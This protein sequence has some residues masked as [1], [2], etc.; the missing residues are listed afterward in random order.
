MKK[1]KNNPLKKNNNLVKRSVFIIL[2]SILLSAVLAL[3]IY[4][5]YNRFKDDLIRNEQDRLL[6]IADT[7]ARSIE[8]YISNQQSIL[9]ILERDLDVRAF[10]EESSDQK[11]L[12]V[13]DKMQ[14]FLS[15]QKNGFEGIQLYRTSSAL[16]GTYLEPYKKNANDNIEDVKE[17]F[18]TNLQTASEVYF[19]EGK[20]PYF[21][22]N[23]PIWNEEKVIGNIRARISIN[24]IYQ[25]FIQPIKFEKKGYAS[26]KTSSSVFIMH[27]KADQLGQ[28]VLKIR[29]EKYPNYDWS[30]LEEMFDKQM[31]GERG[32]GVYK[33]VWVTDEKPKLTLKF[34]GYS[35]AYFG[36][37]F[38]IVTVSSDYYEATKYIRT[39]LY[40]TIIVMSIIALSCSLSALYIVFMMMKQKKLNEVGVLLARVQDLNS[41]LENDIEQ[42]IILENNLRE[43]R[44]KF[45][46]LFNTGTQLTF[47][48]NASSIKEGGLEILEVN[49][50]ACERLG[51]TRDELFQMKLSDILENMTDQLITGIEKNR[52][53]KMMTE[54]R[55]IC[56]ETNFTTSR[57]DVFPVELY[58]HEFIMEES[59]FLMFV[60]RDI[61]E[62]KQKD[63][64]I[65]K[66]RGIMIY[67]SRLAAMGEMIASIAHQWRQ[68]LSRL[69]LIIGNIEDAYN[70]DELEEVYFKEQIS[71]TQTI[72]Q[73]M[74]AIIDEF[75]YFFNPNSERD[76]FFLIK[77][78]KT[79][80]DMLKDRL[81]IYEI[82][83]IIEAD[84]DIEILGYHSQ[85]SQ[86]LLNLLNNSIDALKLCK[87]HRKI[88]IRVIE[89]ECNLVIEILDN[90]GGI[91]D[92]NMIHLFTPYFSTKN[93]G[94][95]TGIGLYISKLIIERNF[96]GML[97]L[98]NYE[99]GLKAIISLDREGT[100]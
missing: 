55:Q 74:S 14:M 59:L 21:Y 96:G 29:K 65:E 43:S 67:K 99:D 38:W 32:T 28:D 40:T 36:N 85:F 19:D 64:L 89:T 53:E 75:L 44:R 79:S 90:G 23:Q 27:P 71:K 100:V 7:I 95:G 4:S 26:V 92:E 1:M 68:P 93:K 66:N 58:V 73:E 24:K 2:L 6:N 42:R 72:V 60:G 37:D 22:L 34:N 20:N 69:N 57:N 52:T 83:T 35:P 50:Y 56:I 88:E 31:N 46:K 33:S 8:S 62:K 18:R 70:Y 39:N 82:E 16:I 78:V 49:D 5:N 86:V 54:N 98:M 11:S 63:K 9:M 97:S 77:T 80:I 30:D 84:N 41:E 51:Y 25:N 15:T 94:E 47:V 48:V 91:A 17:A 76:H 61:T 87:G 81:N 3:I 13:S 45:I 10:L 12:A